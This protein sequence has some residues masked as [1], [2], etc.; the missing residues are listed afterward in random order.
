VTHF[1]WSPGASRLAASG[2]WNALPAP[3]NVSKESVMSQK[4][5]E[6][7]NPRA[8]V[9]SK[10]KVPE[11]PITGLSPDDHL[12]SGSDSTGKPGGPIK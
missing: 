6:K 4:V 2:V 7:P 11:P 12:G 5:N 8:S 1:E 9:T 3:V 10:Q